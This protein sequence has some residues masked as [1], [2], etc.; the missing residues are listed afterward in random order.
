MIYSH[1]IWSSLQILSREIYAFNF[2]VVVVVAAAGIHLFVHGGLTLWKIWV[3]P[4]VIAWGCW[5]HKF[6]TVAVFKNKQ[7]T[8]LSGIISV[9]YVYRGTVRWDYCT[10][11][12]QS[13][14]V[15]GRWI[16]V[17]NFIAV[18][19]ELI[20]PE[21]LFCSLFQVVFCRFLT[22][23][24]LIFRLCKE[25]N[26]PVTHRRFKSRCSTSFGGSIYV[27]GADEVPLLVP[28]VFFQTS[29]ERRL[30]KWRPQ[31]IIYLFNCIYLGR[32]ET[33]ALFCVHFI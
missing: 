10:L 29:N 32:C 31:F 21:L 33:V 6:Y 3:T 24:L 11:L 16:R 14:A 12:L 30:R 8:H 7:V 1:S 23:L 15:L 19:L 2:L 22:V 4:V 13:V 26:L 28:F 17:Q 18:H 20:L 25:L 5:W 27:G 9:Y